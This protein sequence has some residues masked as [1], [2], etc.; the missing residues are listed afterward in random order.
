MSKFKVS[1]SF[2]V[3]Y[4]W[5]HPSCPTVQF[6]PF[7]VYLSL[8][9]IP[10]SIKKN[11]L[12]EFLYQEMVLMPDQANIWNLYFF[13]KR[14]LD[15]TFSVR[16]KYTLYW[17][18][19]MWKI[20]YEVCPENSRKYRVKNFQSYLEAIQ[21]CHLQSTPLYSV[22]TAAS[23]SSMFWSIPGRLF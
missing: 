16:Q 12:Y 13:S 1:S 6:H 17:T 19:S 8:C 21:P 15:M 18:Y 14:S 20:M 11:I 2:K 4:L 10:V 22:C 7:T 5:S 9:S 3:Q 23:I